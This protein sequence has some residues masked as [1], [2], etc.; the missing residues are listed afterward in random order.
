MRRRVWLKRIL[1]IAIPPVLILG[2]LYGVAYC[3]DADIEGMLSRL[4]PLI[5]LGP[6][7]VVADV[8]AGGGKLSLLLAERAGPEGRVFATELGEAK[9]ASL[10]ETAGRARHGNITVVESRA[11]DANL[12]PECCDAVILSK[13]YHHLT[14]PGAVNASLLASL[15]P[16]GRLAVIDFPDSMLMFWLPRVEGVPHNRGRHGIPLDVVRA[17]LIDAGFLIERVIEDWW[18]FPRVRYCVIARKQR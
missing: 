7:S 14:D 6:G 2:A 1:W 12:P 18:E 15:R 3:R 10:R 9:L 5:E 11:K 4:A 17:E 8:G 13:V 16:G